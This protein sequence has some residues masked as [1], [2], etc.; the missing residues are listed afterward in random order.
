M[1]YTNEA[2]A[3]AD[4]LY[5][6]IVRDGDSSISKVSVISRKQF[7]SM[8]DVHMNASEPVDDNSD[9]NFAEYTEIRAEELKEVNERI[10]N[11]MS[12]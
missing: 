2:A 8:V 3:N 6:N 12:K 5:L 4:Y 1:I 11:S 7:I 10:L 9:M